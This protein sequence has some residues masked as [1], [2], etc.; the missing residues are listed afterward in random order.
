MITLIDTD[1]IGLVKYSCLSFVGIKIAIVVVDRIR[2]T[3]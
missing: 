1:N 3:V 2:F